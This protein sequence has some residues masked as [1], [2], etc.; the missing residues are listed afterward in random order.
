MSG[1]VQRNAIP[2]KVEI[3]QKDGSRLPPEKSN[4][5]E[6]AHLP[7]SER[8][9]LF[10]LSQW[11][12]GAVTSFLQLNLKQLGELLKLLH[13]I[14]CFF[15]ANK[16]EKQIQWEDGNLIG[17]SEFI[18]ISEAERPRPVR[19][20]KEEQV[21]ESTTVK[22]PRPEYNGP[23]IEIEGSTEY[24]RII[25]PSSEHPSYS[26]VLRILRD[27]NF[28]RDRAHRHW[29]WLRDES[30]VLDFL[31]SHQEDLELDFGA[32]FTENFRKQTSVIQKAELRTSASETGDSTEVEVRIQAGEVPGD[33]L[34]HALATGKNHVRHGPKVYLLTRELKDKASSLQ[35]RISGNPDAPL[36]AQTSHPIEKFQ[37]PAMEEFLI[38]ADPRFQPP[39]KWKKRSCS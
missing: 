11:C 38:G 15:L 37:A 31:A 32:E 18:E 8:T 2:A 26:E 5:A 19:E 16:P 33:E 22:P 34:E 4:P 36:L 35:K 23:S 6:F 17:V 24:L 25:L 12:G 3:E 20:I 28:L 14:P 9:A 30:K 27:W 1:C 13:D 7:D 10:A 21:E 29:W 39:S